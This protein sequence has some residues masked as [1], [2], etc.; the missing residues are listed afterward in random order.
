M[1]PHVAILCMAL[2][3]AS[4]ASLAD[5]RVTTELEFKGTIDVPAPPPTKSCSA[6]LGL[7]YYQKGTHAS[8]KSTLENHQCGASS[9][10]YVIRIRYRTDVGDMDS[11]EFDETWSREDDANIVTEKDYYV[12]EDL[13]I[14]RVSSTRLRCECAERPTESPN[15]DDPEG[16]DVGD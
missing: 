5:E 9:G 11:V 6:T 12:G 16:S 2:T 7:E 15:A 10:S 8:V 4:A 1:K 13:E 14:R 3:T